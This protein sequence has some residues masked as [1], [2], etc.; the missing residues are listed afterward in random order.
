MDKS[1]QNLRVQTWILC[2]ALILFFIKILAWYLTRSVAILTD[3]LESIVNIIAGIVGLYSLSIAYKPRDTNH[4]YGHGKAE[5]L[6]AAIEGTLIMLA[7]VF[8]IYEAVDQLF[9]PRE[10]QKLNYGIVLVAISA[11]INFV[12]GFLAVRRGKAND[13]D[14]LQ[15]SGHH[16]QSDTY[17][18]LAIILGLILI[19]FTH[20]HQL[21]SI[22]AIIISVVIMFIGYRIA[23]KSVA[24]IMDE[25]DEKILAKVI[26]LVNKS[27]LPNWIDIHNLRVIKFGNV[28]HIDCHMTVPWYLNVREA[29]GEVENLRNIIEKEF[30]SAMEFFVH[31]DDCI[32]SCCPICIKNDC[33][34]REHAFVKKI[35]WKM[36]NA[37]P[38]KKHEFST[39][40]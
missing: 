25:A 17:S 38:N 12:V 1:K 4:P 6:S 5:F 26:D 28:L 35:E 40:S 23:R 3:A 11:I 22:V 39:A 31:A 9:H 34:V 19:Y 33:H 37:V 2:V 10:L 16:L 7:G 8:I 21:D 29:H 24:G 30:G 27:R 36:E 18:T 13:S 14:A 32:E 20:I 15:A